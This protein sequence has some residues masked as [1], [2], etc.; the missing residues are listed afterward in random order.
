MVT[1]NSLDTLNG[2]ACCTVVDD[3][4][5]T[6]TAELYQFWGIN[7]DD[8]GTVAAGVMTLPTLCRARRLGCVDRLYGVRIT[9]SAAID[10]N[11]GLCAFFW[12]NADLTAGY[13]IRVRSNSGA[14]GESSRRGCL[15]ELCLANGSVIKSRYAGGGAAPLVVESRADQDSGDAWITVNNSFS[16]KLTYAEAI[17]EAGYY[18]FGADNSGDELDV[19]S[20]A[21]AVVGSTDI[22]QGCIVG[23]S[24]TEPINACTHTEP[25]NGGTLD[26][27]FYDTSTTWSPYWIT[28]TDHTLNP[29]WAHFLLNECLSPLTDR[30]STTDLSA[31]V[32]ITGGGGVEACGEQPW[33]ACDSVAVR[34]FVRVTS[35][36][37][38]ITLTID[39][40]KSPTASIVASVQLVPMCGT[41]FTDSLSAAWEETAS[42]PPLNC[43]TS[44]SDTATKVIN[45]IPVGIYAIVLSASPE[46]SSFWG[47]PF[48]VELSVAGVEVYELNCP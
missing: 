3:S 1:I 29:G 16:W 25:C 23:C 36:T 4:F 48:N 5:S 6:D 44:E 17:A 26:E 10:F 18:G 32:A 30:W 8:A 19:S 11:R 34:R 13:M 38:E 2:A 28:A 42:A 31:T 40:S 22:T 24:T 39:M 15:V 7:P 35:C 45:N 20:Y 47:S 33:R 12:C 14:G 37:N 41:D 43:T 9:I 21:V 46:N 27:D